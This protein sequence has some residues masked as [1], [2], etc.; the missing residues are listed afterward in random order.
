MAR[1]IDSRRSSWLLVAFVLFHLMA[2]SHQVDGGGGVSLLER[3]VLTA[4]GPFQRAT[5]GA[6]HGV[7][8]FWNHYVDLREVHQE[9][10]R[11]RQR[12]EELQTLVRER[13]EKTRQAERLQRILGLREILPY[14]R[15]V[16][17]VIAR[18][19]QPWFRT[20][21]LNKGTEHGI[22]LNAPVISPE[23][24]LGRVIGVGPRVARVQLLQDRDC[25]VGARIE[26]SRVTGVVSGQVGVAD[27]GTPEL[28]MK[29]VPAEAD[30][31]V[32]DVVVTSGLDR[33]FPKGLVVGRVLSVAAPAGLFKEVLVTPAVRFALIEEAVVL[34]VE[35]EAL[36]V[37]E[38]VG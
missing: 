35:P 33:I 34:R 17:D 26:R 15:V 23:G 37:A 21:T 7:G 4:L 8:G 14:E 12:V 11:L 6:I 32:G 1:V 3:F 13:E 25:G 27:A 19:G 18:D 36:V 20:L 38:E 5:A 22:G 30:V 10:E 24:V 29:Y 2:I 9:N 16:A 31:A 28:L